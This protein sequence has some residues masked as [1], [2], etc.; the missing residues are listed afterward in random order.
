MKRITILAMLMLVVCTVWAADIKLAVP[1]LEKG[2][3]LLCEEYPY[4]SVKNTSR[5]VYH[6]A[7]L[8]FANVTSFQ[9]AHGLKADGVLGPNT[10][11]K[12]ESE[13]NRQFK[14]KPEQY[15]WKAS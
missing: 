1:E 8:G 13:F 10:Q 11:Q 5:T 4:R 9:D 14:V 6:L 12:A 3:I 2:D 7:R 15:F